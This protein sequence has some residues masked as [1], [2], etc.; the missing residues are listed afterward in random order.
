MIEDVFTARMNMTVKAFLKRCEE[1]LEEYDDDEELACDCKNG[2]ETCFALAYEMERLVGSLPI[3]SYVVAGD[4]VFKKTQTYRFLLENVSVDRNGQF[5]WE[6][7]REIPGN[8]MISEIERQVAAGK[9]VY[10]TKKLKIA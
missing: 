9:T 5:G 8:W 4:S 6:V 10:A 3:G 2:D 1:V 7:G